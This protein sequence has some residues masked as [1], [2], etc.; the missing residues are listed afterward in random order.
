M[1]RV[2]VLCYHAVSTRWNH[3][4]AAHPD[5]LHSQLSH[6]LRRG[7]IP[8]TFSAAVGANARRALCVTFD[9]AF[10]S[11]VDIALP[12]LVDLGIVATMFVPTDYVQAVRELTWAGFGDLPTPPP[13]GELAS[14]SWDDVRLLSRSGW[15]IGSHTRSHP[16]LTQLHDG[17]LRDELAGSRRD[18]EEATGA[19]CNAIA[20]PYGDVDRRVVDAAR[21]AGYSY[22]AGL[23]LQA[24]ALVSHAWPRM[25]IYRSDRAARF[26]VK[27]SAPARSRAFAAGVTALRGLR[28]A[29]TRA[30][31]ST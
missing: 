11:V 16:R 5:Q 17:A 1:N 7:Y 25:G 26:A 8:M 14:M 2:C 20:Y 22:G 18:C 24:H 23:G 29:G 15:E 6:L 28:E 12:I 27:T 21:Q 19:R 30:I 4:A 31:A 10:R 9:D 3:P 13:P